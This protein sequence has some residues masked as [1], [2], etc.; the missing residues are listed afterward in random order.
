MDLN[1]GRWNRILTTHIRQVEAKY[2]VPSTTEM[3]AVLK[4]LNV[5]THWQSQCHIVPS[6]CH[7]ASKP[8]RMSYLLTLQGYPSQPERH[9]PHRFNIIGLSIIHCVL[10]NSSDTKTPQVTWTVQKMSRFHYVKNSRA[11]SFY[12]VAASTVASNIVGLSNCIFY[13]YGPDTEEKEI[14]LIRDSIGSSSN[15][16]HEYQPY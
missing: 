3:L 12:I 9:Q 11:W 10:M 7:R 6:Q 14:A 5:G 15:S 13:P 2:K 4:A 8:A 16:D 1:P